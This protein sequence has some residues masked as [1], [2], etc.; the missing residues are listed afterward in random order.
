MTDG[1]LQVG[2]RSPKNLPSP[3]KTTT[4]LDEQGHPRRSVRDLYEV[5]GQAQRS[6]VRRAHPAATFQ[7]LIRR[8][9]NRQQRYNRDGFEVG[10][11][12]KLYDLQDASERL[13][14]RFTIAI[15]QSGLSKAKAANDQLE[16]LAATELYVRQVAKADFCVFCGA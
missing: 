3:G 16:L 13:R 10:N 1:P 2:R 15:A 7:N 8:E 4:T 6:T 12:T 11:L 5:C 9:R 14:P